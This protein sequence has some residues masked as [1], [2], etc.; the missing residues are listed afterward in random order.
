[1]QRDVFRVW[2]DATNVTVSRSDYHSNAHN[3]AFEI[4]RTGQCEWRS[5]TYI[6]ALL[7]LQSG[8]RNREGES[9]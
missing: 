8:E 7:I 3:D 2:P 9:S 1:M 4:C 5:S 6:M